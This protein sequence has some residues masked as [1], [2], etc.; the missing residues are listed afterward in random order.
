M[1]HLLV[2]S[3]NAAPTAG[4][5]YNPRS[6][7]HSVI[8]CLGMLW[9]LIRASPTIG[10]ALQQGHLTFGIN[11]P[12]AG[13]ALDLAIGTPATWQ[14]TRAPRTMAEIVTEG[15]MALTAQEPDFLSEWGD[16]T[17]GRIERVRIAVEAKA[18][19]TDHAGAMPRVSDELERF[20]MRV[21]DEAITVGLILVNLAEEFISPGR[22]WFD[23]DL[24]PKYVSLHHQPEAAQRVIQMA[25]SLPRRERD[26]SDGFDGLGMLFVD[27]RND[28]TPLRTR[29]FGPEHL[30]YETAIREVVRRYEQSFPHDGAAAQTLIAPMSDTPRSSWTT[31]VG[32]VPSPL[33]GLREEN[34][35][36]VI[37][38]EQREES[39]RRLEEHL[40]PWRASRH[41][42][43]DPYRRK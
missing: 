40:K 14:G 24:N 12:V 26:G 4:W 35:P 25:D 18:V 9:D 16:L 5:A 21:Q 22:N 33:A 1:P 29:Q 20:R 32:S 23:P 27:C 6:D 3:L 11:T 28:G 36:I 2:R 8:K 37:T 17:E 38:P 31:Q 15:Q 34:P 30:A 7:R 39:K 41:Y 42:R 19:M 13:K 10:E 43:P